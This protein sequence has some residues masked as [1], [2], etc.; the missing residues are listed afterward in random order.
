VV[1]KK[2][3]NWKWRFDEVEID[4]DSDADPNFLLGDEID[5]Q[6]HMKFNIESIRGIPR[7][8]EDSNVDDA[9]VDSLK[10]G[11]CE[12]NLDYKY[13]D[14]ESANDNEITKNEID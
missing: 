2:G 4:H 5:L 11:D 7:I 12:Y 14:E 1:Q 6:N 9:Y 8:F 3:E 10:S 13:S